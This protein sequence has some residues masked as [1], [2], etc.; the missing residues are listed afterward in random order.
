[1]KLK[2]ILSLALSGVLAISMLAGCGGG[3]ISKFLSNRTSTVVNALNDS[4]VQEML[5]YKSSDKKLDT[6]VAQVAETLTASQAT[7][8]FADSGVAA[9]VQQLTSYT[10]M[11]LADGW[12]AKPTTGTY[13]KVFTYK[14]DDANSSYAN[15]AE[16]AKDIANKLAIMDLKN[17]DATEGE[18][19]T[20][21]YAGNVA[22]YEKTIGEGD[23]AVTV[24]V[25]GV[26]VTQTATADK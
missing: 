16:V 8:G 11:W 26:A 3:S 18:G 2:R 22:A 13:V 1:M 19:F 4:S 15:A 24:W 17:K 12:K 23:S 14:V 10:D 25:V 6:A 7:D 20:N 9:T 5:T 21:S